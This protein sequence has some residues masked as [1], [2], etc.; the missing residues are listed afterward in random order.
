MSHV[1]ERSCLESV[2]VGFDDDDAVV[3]G[4]AATMTAEAG[5]ATTSASLTVS[6][7]KAITATAVSS[8]K[9][10]PESV[11]VGFADEDDD[12]D[13]D[14]DAVVVGVAVESSVDSSCHASSS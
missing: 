8:T 11:V 12:D 2:F 5:A 10:I 6:S 9:S 1:G 3:G 7:W 4:V 14:D 13:Y